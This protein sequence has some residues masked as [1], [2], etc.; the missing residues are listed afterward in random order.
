MIRSKTRTFLVQAWLLS[1]AIFPEKP[2][3][4]RIVET[5]IHPQQFLTNLNPLVKKSRNNPTTLEFRLKT[6]KNIRRN[7]SFLKCFSI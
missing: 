1:L 2:K 6:L 5:K 3:K 7:K 4:N